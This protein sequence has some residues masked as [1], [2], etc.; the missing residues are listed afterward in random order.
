[1]GGRRRFFRFPFSLFRCL[2][3][4]LSNCPAVRRSSCPAVSLLLST[5]FC[6]LT[7]VFC[8]P[9]YSADLG[10][11]LGTADDIT[12]QGVEGTPADP[13]AHFWG[14]T[15]IGT[16]TAGNQPSLSVSSASL[17][18]Q[19]YLE[20]TDRVYFWN[21]TGIGS[22]DP[23]AKLHILDSGNQP[24]LIA[25]HTAGG[26]GLFVSS[27]GPVGIGLS[28]ASYML[29]IATGAGKADEILVISTGASNIFRVTGEGKVYANRYYGDGSQLSGI[30]A[31]ANPGGSDTYVQF[32]DGGSALGGNSGF[33]FQK[34]SGAV[35]IGT[36][37]PSA[38]LHISSTNAPGSFNILQVSSGTAA[39]QE[40]MVIKGDGKVGIGTTQPSSALEVQSGAI[41]AKGGFIVEVRGADPGSPVT[42]Q[43][44]L[45]SP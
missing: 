32:N 14:L 44:W 19:K 21:Q 18:V 8:S 2:S 45:I 27:W 22:R 5:V 39:G 15:F 23:L 4:L 26:Y 13:D 16:T 11:E 1:M 12:G 29:H 9:I 42:G 40:L 33:V 43:V 31:G 6:L 20:A 41:N 36:S 3:P 28:T 30:T 10:Y 35:G 37:E 17:F 34:S 7:S 24:L 38:K 25:S